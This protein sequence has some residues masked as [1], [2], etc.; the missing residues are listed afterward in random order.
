MKKS[1]EDYRL[2]VEEEDDERERANFQDFFTRRGPQEQIVK[3][4]ERY[5][6]TEISR[7]NS[8]LKYLGKAREDA[9][10]RLNRL[11]R[12]LGE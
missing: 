4:Y 7:L 5:L 3:E 6:S 9:E 10:L 8:G 1:L 11:R 12:I 2:A